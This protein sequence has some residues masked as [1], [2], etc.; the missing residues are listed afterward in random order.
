MYRAT[1]MEKIAER[2]ILAGANVNAVNSNNETPWDVT[3]KNNYRS[4][5]IYLSLQKHKMTNCI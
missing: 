4:K 5:F 3:S 1:G 2:L